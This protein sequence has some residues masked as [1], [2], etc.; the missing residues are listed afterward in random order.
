MNTQGLVA[1]I[2]NATFSSPRELGTILARTP[3]CQEC[4]VKQYFR[5]IAGRAET[6]ADQPL[7]DRVLDDFR[8]SGFHFQDMMV[9]LIGSREFPNLERSVHV[10]SNHQAR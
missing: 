8:K 9:S 10:A 3:Q 6:P 2:A 4:M 1:G 5:Y 7:I